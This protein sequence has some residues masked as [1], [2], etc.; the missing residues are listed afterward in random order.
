[1]WR[2]DGTQWVPAFAGAPPAARH[3]SRAWIWW[4]AGGCALLLVLGLVGAVVG[5]VALY[6]SFQRGAFSCLPS[7]F[8]NYPGATVTSENTNTGTA[9]APGDSKS[10]L[11]VLHSND[12]IATVASFYNEKLSSGD[13]KVTAFVST[14]G[15]IRFHRVS[16]EATVGLVQVQARGQQTVITIQL[17][18]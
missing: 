17:D 13:W 15:Q 16:S 18:S 7:D 10:C 14:Y 4:L 2:W 11:M 8:P 5:G 9:V 3:G 6:G 12:D 1:M